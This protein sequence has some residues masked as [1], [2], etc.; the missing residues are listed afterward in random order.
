M[1]EP[2]RQRVMQLQP[3]LRQICPAEHTMAIVDAN[4][5]LKLLA[6]G[7]DIDDAFVQISEDVLERADLVFVSLQVGEPLLTWHGPDDA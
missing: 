7:T 6:S 5:Q 1:K 2:L 3:H 4:Q